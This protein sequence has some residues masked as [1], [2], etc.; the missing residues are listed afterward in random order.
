[1]SRTKE[2]SLIEETPNLGLNVVAQE[3]RPAETNGL[4]HRRAE[5]AV[6][7]SKRRNSAVGDSGSPPRFQHCMHAG[8]R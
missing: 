1:M 7:F 3:G 4:S 8:T 5:L 2:R 6:F